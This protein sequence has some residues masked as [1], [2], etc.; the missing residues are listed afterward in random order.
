MSAPRRHLGAGAALSVLAQAGPLVAAAA[1][2]IVLARTIGPSGNGHY[3]LLVTLVGTT[4]MVVALGLHSGITY[5]VSRRRWSVERAFRTSYRVA[6]LLGTVGVLGGL[7]VFVL[8]RDTVFDGIPLGVALVALLSLPAMIAYEYG[9]TIM[10]ARE[11]YEAY[12]LIILHA[13]PLP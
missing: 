13:T 6:L 2:S 4:S 3:A 1:L 7:A 8:T 9:V 5:E 12:G 11:R 10:L